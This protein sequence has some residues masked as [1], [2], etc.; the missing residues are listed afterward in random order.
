METC[1]VGGEK[2]GERQELWVHAGMRKRFGELRKS[3]QRTWAWA[4]NLTRDEEIIKDSRY[5]FDIL[6]ESQ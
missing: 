1:F 4:E 6:W 3:L 5:S 2:K